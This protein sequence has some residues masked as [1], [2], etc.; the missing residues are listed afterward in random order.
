[1][2]DP[3]RF[4]AGRLSDEEALRVAGFPVGIALPPL[5]LPA[6]CLAVA[7]FTGLE[8]DPGGICGSENNERHT[9]KER[10]A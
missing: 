2:P 4:G 3:A 10:L 5:P 1:M 9:D 6:A 7:G 8:P